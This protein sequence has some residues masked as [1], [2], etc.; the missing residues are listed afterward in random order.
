MCEHLNWRIKGQKA[1]ARR[2]TSDS[3]EAFNVV[4]KK[5][6]LRLMRV[7]RL[8]PSEREIIKSQ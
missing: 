5:L 8:L 1:R 7:G 2:P 3:G 4:A 6:R